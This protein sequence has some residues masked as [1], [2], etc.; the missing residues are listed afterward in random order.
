[1]V[2]TEK[3]EEKLTRKQEQALLALLEKG[4]VR[5]ASKAC[6][7][8]ETTLWRWLRESPEFRKRYQA[9]RHQLVDTAIARLQSAGDIAVT[10]LVDIAQDTSAAPTA[11]IAAARAIISGAF[12][13]LELGQAGGQ[14]LPEHKHLCNVCYLPFTCSDKADAEFEFATC[15]TCKVSPRKP[16]KEDL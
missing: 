2:D 6:A 15:P 5:E 9:A 11:R 16:E 7:I 8:S 1:M 12:R 13:G 4:T 14:N 10:T 3:T